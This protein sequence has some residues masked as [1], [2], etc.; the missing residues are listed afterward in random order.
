VE[1]AVIEKFISNDGT[2]MA[3]SVIAT[4]VI[5]EARLIH[6]SFPVASA[7]LGRALIGAGLLA[8]FLKEKGR[9]ALYFK[10]DGPLG[11]IFA[12]GSSDGSVRGFVTNP[13]IHV[14]SKNGKLN[15]GGG[16]GKGVLSVAT[17]LPNE[18][19]P[20]TGT[21]TLQSGEIGE[22]IAYYLFQSQQ[23]PSIVALGVFV[24]PDN[25]ISAAGGTIVQVMPGVSDE[26]L[27]L[28]EARVKQI[29]P[30]TELIRDGA[31]TSDLAYEVLEDFKFRKLDETLD[32]T[33]AC[34][35]SLRKVERSL[36][37]L[38]EKDLTELVAKNEATEVRCDFCGRKYSVDH[39]TLEGLLGI[40]KKKS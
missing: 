8:S 14:P 26:S 36:L 6:N 16:V 3:S 28:L 27:A 12:E 23:I 33:Y 2:I 15:V 21:V 1:K 9:M 32:L 34:Q 24:E 22:D 13:Q 17:S 4:S 19:Q 39:E 7:A 35:C 37:L 18:K 38:G 30:V 5:E 11:N 25:S 20:Y 10:G 31:K 40:A 29:R